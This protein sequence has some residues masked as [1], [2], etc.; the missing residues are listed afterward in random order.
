MANCFF[1]GDRPRSF[2]HPSDNAVVSKVL[3]PN[4]LGQ[5]QYRGRW[6]AAMCQLSI[7]VPPD[8]LVR[9]VQDLGDYLLV[10]PLGS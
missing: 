2:S 5:V 9:V 1:R 3:K 7:T 8:T 6:L 10:I 4:C